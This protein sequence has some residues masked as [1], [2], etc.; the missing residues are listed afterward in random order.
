MDDYMRA[1]VGEILSYAKAANDYL[2]TSVYF[3]GGTPSFIE[4]KNIADVMTVLREN[5]CFSISPEVTVEANPGTISAEKLQRYREAGI[6]RLS[7][8]VQAV[9]DEILKEIGR[10]HRFADVEKGYFEARKAGFENISFD[11]MFGLP[12]Q[13]LKDVEESLEVFIALGPEHISAYSLKVEEHTVFGRL[14]KEKKLILPSEEEER[15]MYYLVKK[16]LKSAGYRQYEISNF[17]KE[18]RESQHNLAY[19]KRT[20]YFGFGAGAASCFE[21]CRCSNEESLEGYIEKEEKK[22]YEEKLTKEV[23]HSETIIL[24]LRLM[25]GVQK[26]LFFTEKE[27]AAVKKLMNYGLLQEDNERISL[28][29]RGLDLANQVFVEFI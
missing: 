9:Q 21:N 15:E 2:V 5:Y 19:W 14:Q 16:R 27:K 26:E 17:A 13:T 3:G 4:A 11:L 10:I 24:G 18:G 25:E 20:D 28:T 7:F 12:K 22:V 8:G 1:L 6:N 23:I 29:E